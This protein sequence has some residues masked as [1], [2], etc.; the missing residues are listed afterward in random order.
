MVIPLF[1]SAELSFRDDDFQAMFENANS[2][3]QADLMPSSARFITNSYDSDRC[4]LARCPVG[5]FMA[6]RVRHSAQTVIGAL[7]DPAMSFPR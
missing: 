4:S 7:V 5:N 2:S 6:V 1:V 3:N